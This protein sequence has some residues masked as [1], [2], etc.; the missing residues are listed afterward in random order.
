MTIQ[1]I[2]DWIAQTPG[3]QHAIGRYQFIPATLRRLV[4]QLGVAQSQI[5]TPQIQDR[6][7]DILLV[8]AGLNAFGQGDIERHAFMNNLARIWAGL[9]TSSGKSYYDGIAGN[10]A[11]MT[12]AYF[13]H[14]MSLIFPNSQS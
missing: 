10:R 13:D 3:Q 11:S 5:F 12:W 2:Y 8:E 4:A 6:L 14:Q 9:P 7:G 1:E